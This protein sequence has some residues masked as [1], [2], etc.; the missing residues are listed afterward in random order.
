MSKSGAKK[1]TSKGENKMIELANILDRDLT[2]LTLIKGS[3]FS[4]FLSAKKK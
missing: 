4:D 1:K 2:N 3:S